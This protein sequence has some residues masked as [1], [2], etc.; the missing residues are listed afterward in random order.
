MSKGT[1]MGEK[2][3]KFVAVNMALVLWTKW[4]LS[5]NIFIMSVRPYTLPMTMKSHIRR[6]KKRLQNQRLGRQLAL[7]SVFK[8]FLHRGGGTM[9]HPPGIFLITQKVFQICSGLNFLTF[10]KIELGIFFQKIEVMGLTWAF[11]QP[12]LS[13][14]LKNLKIEKCQFRGQKAIIE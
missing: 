5:N 10:N 4:L 7:G 6:P 3:A 11:L 12:F 1:A 13:P 9:Y 14:D 8:P 2:F